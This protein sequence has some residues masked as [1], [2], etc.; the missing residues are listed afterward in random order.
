MPSINDQS[1]FV[2]GKFRLARDPGAI[3][4]EHL[5]DVGVVIEGGISENR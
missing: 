4:T 1:G 3:R 5:R 2:V